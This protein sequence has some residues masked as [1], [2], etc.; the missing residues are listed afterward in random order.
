MSVDIREAARKCLIEPVHSI[1]DRI[2]FPS[3]NASKVAKS[4]SFYFLMPAI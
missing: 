1:F 4:F 2:L 3:K